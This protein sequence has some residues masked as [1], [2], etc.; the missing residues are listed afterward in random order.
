MNS[1]YYYRKDYYQ[2]LGVTKD[3]SAEDIKKAFRRL[4]LRYHPDR[5][6]GNTEESEEKFKEINEAH[7]VL[8]DERKRQEYD[9]IIS[10]PAYWYEAGMTGRYSANLDEDAIRMR[11]L[12]RMFSEMGLGIGPFGGFGFNEMRCCRRSSIW[13][14]FRKR[15]QGQQ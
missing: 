8:G 12:M 15:A 7:E 14:Y 1:M 5:N 9:Q 2:I 13:D 11:S 3:A 4:A 6:P 10:Q